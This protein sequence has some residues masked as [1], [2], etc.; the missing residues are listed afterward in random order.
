MVDIKK[1]IALK[2]IGGTA[3]LAS[4]PSIVNAGKL[5]ATLDKGDAANNAANNIANNSINNGAELT[6]SLSAGAQSTI[7]LT[8]I[9]E[10]TIRLKHIHPG[11]V[12]AGD[13]TFDI[14][15]IFTNGAQAL[16]PGISREFKIDQTHGTQKETDFP[17]YLYG[18][19]PQRVV[20][21]T[22]SDKQGLFVNSSR[23]F[24]S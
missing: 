10:Q 5:L 9:S 20:S 1:R 16:E 14:N 13:K 17:R 12:H 8:N 6:L 19:R 4:M 24:Y 7:K 15:S 23:S 21:V 3:V 22:G 11:I 2:V 18:K